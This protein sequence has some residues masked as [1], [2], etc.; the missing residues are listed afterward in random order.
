MPTAVQFAAWRAETQQAGYTTPAAFDAYRGRQVWIKHENGLITRY[1]HLSAIA[2]G[3]VEGAAVVQG[4]VVGAVGNSGS[5]LSLE[6]ETADAHLHFELRL[7]DYYVGQF[8]RPI[9]A[10][11]WIETALKK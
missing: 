5:P 7:G 1:V 6:S 11:E 8:L 9:E 10:R 4:Q 2:P 3:I